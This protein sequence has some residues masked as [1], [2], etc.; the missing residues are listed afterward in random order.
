ML[1]G[2]RR[3]APRDPVTGELMLHEGWLVVGICWFSVLVASPGVIALSMID[4]PAPQERWIPWAGC[5][6]FAAMGLA[7][8]FGGER[9]YVSAESIRKEGPFFVRR[10]ARWQDIL[11]VSVHPGGSVLLI[12]K[13]G[14]RIRVEPNLVGF[15]EFLDQLESCAA[16]Q[17]RRDVEDDLTQ[18]RRFLA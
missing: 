1:G 18:L 5:V 15:L 9:V 14:A 3:P 8:I 16:L 10:Q 12:A 4:P 11:D 7:G 2:G 13:D 17:V 6:S